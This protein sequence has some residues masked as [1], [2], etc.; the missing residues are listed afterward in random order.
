MELSAS[1]VRQ[2]SC[3][4]HMRARIVAASAALAAL[5][6]TCAGNRV[7]AGRAG[8]QNRE[9]NEGWRQ[10]R[11][12][13][14]HFSLSVPAGWTVRTDERRIVATSADHSAFAVIGNFVPQ[15]DETAEDHVDNLPRTEAGILPQ[16]RVTEAYTLDSPVKKQA[17]DGSAAETGEQAIGTL[18]YVGDKGPGQ[19]RFLCLVFPKGGLLFGLAASNDRFASQRPAM[20]RILQSFQFN[21]TG[22]AAPG[23]AS[24]NRPG[25]A[26]A[27]SPLIDPTSNFHYVPFS[28][29][30]EHAFSVDVPQGW[31]QDGGTFRASVLDS[32]QTILVRSPHDEMA[33]MLGDAGVPSFTLPSRTLDF[34]HH[35]E[36][37]TI[38]GP[39]NIS[40]LVARF[41]PAREFNHWY[42]SNFM[43]RSVDN[44]EIGEEKENT[45]GGE[46]LTANA[47][48]MLPAGGPAHC[49]VT[50]AWVRF[51]CR[52]KRNGRQM[53]GVLS[54]STSEFIG[55]AQGEG[56]WTARPN[57]SVWATGDS[58]TGARELAAKA[59]GYHMASSWKV[60]AEWSAAETKR[61]KDYVAMVTRVT[62]GSLQANRNA[63][64]QSAAMSRRTVQS[65][66]DRR[67]K[68]M[69]EFR[70][71]M[72]AKD[73]NTRK[74]M[75][76][77]LDQTDVTNGSQSWKVASGYNN[78]YR[79]EASGTIVGT[80]DPGHPGVG[81][82][83]LGQH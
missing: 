78:Y 14:F 51:T 83:Q 37:S 70:Q 47:N 63:A 1:G 55:N 56:N 27:A 68:M 80:N 9:G 50:V 26:E 72:A 23:D 15:N 19:G 45:E 48:K 16:C 69:G 77:S 79:H 54:S 6:L 13:R 22:A 64:A 4:P 34:L 65:S 52:S 30:V 10:Y 35:P 43:S 33:V 75:N 71:R 32:R 38:T 42:L 29:S 73:D 60:N 74:Q 53:A 61:Q 28:D 25:S 7:A 41:M 3:R 49:T 11:D 39:N 81:F 66:D 24:G 57:F 46:K 76:Y 36:G 58:K 59:V 2:P 8:E 82:T 17:A 21:A 18:T 12:T 67:T 62:Q 44:L 40:S 5:L 31:S 20:L